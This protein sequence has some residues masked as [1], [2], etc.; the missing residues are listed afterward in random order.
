[1]PSSLPQKSKWQ[2]VIVPPPDAAAVSAAAADAAATTEA[3]GRF[4][5]G[6]CLTISLLTYHY[7]VGCGTMAR[8]GPCWILFSFVA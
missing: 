1:M 4:E 3:F 8:S 2:S 7:N 5:L 6:R